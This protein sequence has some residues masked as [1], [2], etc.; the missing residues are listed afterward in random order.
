LR[1]VSYDAMTITG[2]LEVASVWARKFP[3]ETVDAVRYPS[4]F[5]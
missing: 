2:T 3:A 5:F 4:L 1:N